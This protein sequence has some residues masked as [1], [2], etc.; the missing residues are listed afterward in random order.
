[1]INVHWEERAFE[2]REGEPDEWLR[3]ADTSLDSPND[4]SEPGSEP[5]LSGLTYLVAPRCVV[6]LKSAPT[7][8]RSHDFRIS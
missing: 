1:M 6:I 7:G 8:S 2:I 3:V 5:R 4:I